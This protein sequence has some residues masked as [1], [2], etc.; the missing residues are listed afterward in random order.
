MMTARF[1]ATSMLFLL[2]CAEPPRLRELV[3]LTHDGALLFAERQQSS[4]FIAVDPEAER[5]RFEAGVPPLS[6]EFGRWAIASGDRVVVLVRGQ[7]G[8]RLLG[9]DRGTGAES[10]QVELDPEPRSRPDDARFGGLWAA[11]DG[12]IIA[13]APSALG[14]ASISLYDSS[15]GER[16]WQA[17]AKVVGDALHDVFVGTHRVAFTTGTLT[18]ILDRKTGA[19]VAAV[20]SRGVSCQVGTRLVVVAAQ[21]VTLW[22]LDSEATSALNI[23]A[24]A[25]LGAVRRCGDARGS[26]D[27]LALWGPSPATSL[28]RVSLSDSQLKWV[29]A[30]DGVTMPTH[31]A[32]RGVSPHDRL[33]VAGRFTLLAL[34]GADAG[35]GWRSLVTVDID[36]GRIVGSRRW[37]ANQPE[38]WLMLP[39]QSEIFAYELTTRLFSR[40]D[41]ATGELSQLLTLNGLREP[42]ASDLSPP[43]VWVTRPESRVEPGAWRSIP[44]R[45]LGSH[46][47]PA[48]DAP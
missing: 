47:A 43:N 37:D 19:E 36:T 3:P 28:T 45:T 8:T 4:F 44:I 41:P 11:S 48:P 40:V 26:N 18:L 5:W 33:G 13:T 6:P 7:A 22:D 32:G 23:P 42:R 17:Q 15:L 20:E 38:R 39:S 9:L 21:G 16:R 14:A 35:A 1:I 25:A 31:S 24:L 30:L 10:F 46:T 2:A 34:S 27:W 12:E 29:V